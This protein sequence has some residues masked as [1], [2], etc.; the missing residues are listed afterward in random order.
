[1]RVTASVREIPQLTDGC[2]E[3]SWDEVLKRW[4]RKPSLGQRVR[5]WFRPWVRVGAPKHVPCF[6]RTLDGR[7]LYR[8]KV[9]GQA[10]FRVEPEPSISAL[11]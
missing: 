11:S 2:G 5:L 7:A 3:L 10:V 9:L 1:M 4:N 6:M 8:Y